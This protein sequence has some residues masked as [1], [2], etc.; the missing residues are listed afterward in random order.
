MVNNCRRWGEATTGMLLEMEG[1]SRRWRSAATPVEAK[2]F[3]RSSSVVTNALRV[4]VTV[5]VR[6]AEMEIARKNIDRLRRKWCGTD[7]LPYELMISCSTSIKAELQGRGTSR[8]Y[9]W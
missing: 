2:G 4:V 3:G 5:E 1:W 8:W 7:V 9:D 6:Q